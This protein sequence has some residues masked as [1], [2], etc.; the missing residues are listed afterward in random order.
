M[1][2]DI[3]ELAAWADQN[4]WTVED[5]SKGYARFY[6]Q[7]GNYVVQYPATPSNP[8]RRMKDLQTALKRAGLAI[9]PPSK[10]E[11]RSERRKEAK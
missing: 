8:Y 10:K 11:R 1:N 3:R 9:P 2:S 7:N 5:D 4:G 6:D